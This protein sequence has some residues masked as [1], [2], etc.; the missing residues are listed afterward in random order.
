MP[1]YRCMPPAGSGGGGGGEFPLSQ[2][3]IITF[4]DDNNVKYYPNILQFTMIF[5]NGNSV[6]DYRVQ[7]MNS[8]LTNIPSNYTVKYGSKINAIP[9]GMWGKN[10]NGPVII[11]NGLLSACQ[12]F[13]NSKYF[14]HPVTFPNSCCNFYMTFFNSNLF[15]SKVVFPPT[16]EKFTS[17]ARVFE[18]TNFNHPV[19]F[20]K[21]CVNLYDAFFYDPAFNQPIVIQDTNVNLFYAFM[22]NSGQSTFA[23]NVIFKADTSGYNNR[24]I[25]T[26]PFYNKNVQ[27]RVNIYANNLTPFTANNVKWATTTALTWTATTNGYYNAAQ[28]IYLYNNVSDALNWFNNYWY[29]MYGEYPVYAEQ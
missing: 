14:N 22:C 1:F 21:N 25:S 19:I 9:Y 28:N 11:E 29:D 27:K 2:D 4:Y 12:M 10:F 3:D 26:P 6:D 20:S 17:F 5:R 8:Y 18:N 24:H 16:C 7:V 23:S 13:G 15:N